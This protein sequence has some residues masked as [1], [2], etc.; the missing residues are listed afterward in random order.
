MKK[1]LIFIICLFVFPI[2]SYGANC[3][4]DK[5]TETSRL[6]NNVNIT[7]EISINNNKPT[8]TIVLTNLTDD[9]GVVDLVTSK[10]H[11]NF[12]A[13]G[14]ELK[15][16]TSTSGRYSFDIYS[17]A[18]KTK[19]GNKAV[20]LPTYNSYYNDELCKDLESYDLCKRWSSYKADRKTFEN[21][22]TCCRVIRF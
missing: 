12:K 8:F 6:V 16:T 1:I 7:Y 5:Y 3:S 14:S 9:M 17:L 2:I 21:E 20:T 22:H 19:I 15:I 13:T 4:N 11:K 10:A 18:C